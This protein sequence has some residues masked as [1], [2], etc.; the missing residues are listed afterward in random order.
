MK[1]RTE[2]SAPQSN[3]NISYGDKTIM[4]GSCFV[5]NISIKLLRAGFDID[6]NPFGIMY[7]P[8]S[9][10]STL[11]DIINKREYTENDL[12]EHQGIFHSFA[13][14]GKFSGVDK[15]SVLLNINQKIEHSFHFLKQAKYLFITFGTARVYYKTDGMMVANC[16][17]LPA[18][19]F[20]NKRL[21]VNEIHCKWNELITLLRTL[22]P[23]L[24]IIF[25]I[26]PI[27]HWKDGSHENQLSKSTL[28]VALDE[29]MNSNTETYYF[30]SYEFMIDDLRDYRFYSEDMLHPNAQAINYIW[31]KFGDSYFSSNTKSTIK[32]WEKIQQALNHK[33]FNAES[34]EY[35]KFIEKAKE[36]ELLFL[37]KNP[38]VINHK[39]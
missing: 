4:I 20:T 27:R 37:E 26:S 17:K 32:E 14:H 13:H 36:T 34:E 3:F 30:P 12:F 16:H 2:I 1:F 10:H 18:R 19:T 38:L 29:I 15:E 8:L 23:D 39:I 22:N 21:S 25:T 6:V 24:R 11:S 31:D 9:I 7:N 33:P 35:T 28:F 5:E